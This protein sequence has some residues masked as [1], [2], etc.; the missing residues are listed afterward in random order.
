MTMVISVLGAI[1]AGMVVQA[2]LTIKQTSAFSAAVRELRTHGAV[3]VG[4]GGKRYH[5]GKAFVAIA[6]DPGG[7]VTKAI[8][9]SGWTTFSRPDELDQVQGL[10][11]KQLRRDVPI[12]LI[13]TPQRAALQS[14]AESLHQHLVKV[15]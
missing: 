1:A 9:L 5:G 14:A 2:I 4:G 7:R 6:A 15:A 3:A 13:G 8:S 11:L 12:P 10:P